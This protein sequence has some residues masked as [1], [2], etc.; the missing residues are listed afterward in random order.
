[1]LV[2]LATAC[3]PV[4]VALVLPFLIFLRARRDSF[5]RTAALLGCSIWGLLGF[6]FYQHLEFDQPLAFIQAQDGFR[7]LCEPAD[8][9]MADKARSLITFQPIWSNYLPSSKTYW[10]AMDCYMCENWLLSLHFANPIFFLTAVATVTIGFW[11]KV[12]DAKEMTFSVAM[13]MI[14]YATRA[15]EMAMTGQGRFTLSAFPIFI[16]LGAAWRKLPLVVRGVWITVSVILLG[17][18]VYSWAIGGLV[19]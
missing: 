19:F 8:T 2:G 16:V 11:K 6:I 14:P 1:M 15:E 4:G 7:Y 3:R 9:S 17:C 13:L 10:K 12:L 18:Y 5:W